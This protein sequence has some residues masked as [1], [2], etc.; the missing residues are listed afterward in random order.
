MGL[1]KQ[2]GKGELDPGNSKE[3][4]DKLDSFSVGLG[5]KQAKWAGGFYRK[6]VTV[7]SDQ[8]DSTGEENENT[9]L[10]REYGLHFRALI[11]GSQVASALI[12]KD[13]QRLCCTLSK[14]SRWKYQLSYELYGSGQT[15]P[16]K[17]SVVVPGWSAQFSLSHRP[18]YGESEIGKSWLNGIIYLGATES[19]RY[20][21]KGEYGYGKGNMDGRDITYQKAAF[22]IALLTYF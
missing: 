15:A 13:P 8:I 20:G 11:S 19:I 10:Y 18:S 1:S 4:N 14:A 3:S 6:S 21:F 12:Q 5:F 16:I 2:N 22:G 17:N 7:K 9:T